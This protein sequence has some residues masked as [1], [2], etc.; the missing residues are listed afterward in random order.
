MK[1]NK[2]LIS[3]FTKMTAICISLTFFSCMKHKMN[4]HNGHSMTALNIDYPAAF[5]VN[6]KGNSISVIRLFDNSVSE[7]ISLNGA[8]FP[9]HIYF[10]PAKTKFA[11]AITNADLSAGHNG[12]SGAIAGVKVQIID[13]ITGNIDKEIGLSK[14]PHNAVYNTS[15]TELWIPQSDSLQG[16]VLIFNTSDWTLQKTINVGKMPSEVT[17]SFNG[18]MVY[19]ANTMDGTISII[20]PISK[21][22]TKTI[23]VG[24]G[25]I[26]AWPA[27]NGKMYVDNESDQSVSEIDVITGMVTS[28]FN[29]GFK[30]GYVSYN[31]KLSELWVSDATNGKIVYYKNIAGTWTSTGSIPTGSDA[32]A[33]IFSSDENKAYITNQG[34]NTVTLV[35][36]VNHLTIRDIAVGSAPNGIIIK[37]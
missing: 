1:N 25:P 33:I 13:A 16:T 23:V 10:N 3:I 7:T 21:L 4:E 12:H 29:L 20:D 24:M 2:N 17:F 8:T 32:H 34:A 30:P 27:A 14:M 5:V 36:V 9:H 37:D 6:G 11:V 15:G 35:D 18:S 31:S 19:V 28:T 22:V 26:G